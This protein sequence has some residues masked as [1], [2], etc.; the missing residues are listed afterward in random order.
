M[1]FSFIV[2]S[3]FFIL[4][5][6]LLIPS[7]PSMAKNSSNS[8]SFILQTSNSGSETVFSS[9]DP[10]TIDLEVN[11]THPNV[12]LV[13]VYLEQTGTHSYK[14]NSIQLSTEEYFSQALTTTNVRIVLAIASNLYTNYT[15][16]G[17][18]RIIQ[19]QLNKNITWNS[20][21]LLLSSPNTLVIFNT[22]SNWVDNVTVN[23]NIQEITGGTLTMNYAYS[24]FGIQKEMTT[25]GTYEYTIKTRSINLMLNLDNGNYSRVV[26]SYT[27]VDNGHI[28]S[29]SMGG[30]SFLISLEVLAVAS[31]IIKKSRH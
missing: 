6:T 10:V 12:N 21:N 13:I 7:T 9:I 29:N 19:G 17:Y 18:F 11:V 1:K 15:A 20:F 25:N 28:S 2:A 16:S 27:I 23:L 5:F 3:C 8:Q 24:D 4:F 30:Y 31:Y 22:N 26:G 14:S